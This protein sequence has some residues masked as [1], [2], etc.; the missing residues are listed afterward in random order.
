M[1][2]KVALVIGIDAYRDPVLD[3]LERC[4]QDADLVEST[5]LEVGFCSEEALTSLRNPSR[6]LMFDTLDLIAKQTEQCSC[7]A[8]IILL[9]YAGH[10]YEDNGM[11][12][13]CPSS[14]KRR[15]DDILLES[16]I[17]RL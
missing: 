5:L 14:S 7:S 1:E 17:Q 16:F 11:I 9:Y 6:D 8:C 10:C 3:D 12:F 4:M 2:G 13:M 15:E